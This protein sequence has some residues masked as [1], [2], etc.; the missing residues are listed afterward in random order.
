MHKISNVHKGETVFDQ[1]SA[2]RHVVAIVLAA[3]QGRRMGLPINKIFLPIH[4]KPVIIYTLEAFERCP[5][6]DEVLLVAAAGEEE[7]LA[8]LTQAAHCQK[9]RRIVQGGPTRHASEQCA[10]EALR[11]RIESGE[12]DL[13]LIHD[14]AR[15]FVLPERIQQLVETARAC[16][17]AILAMP[18]QEEE[19]IVEVDEQQ[20]ICRR[21]AGQR[22]WRAQ[23]P[24]AFRAAWLLAAY[25]RARQDQFEGT[26]TAASLERLGYPVAVVESDQSNLKITTAY[27]LLQAE[28]LC[29]HYGL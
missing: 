13:I 18:L 15:P 3:G 20:A 28:R 19:L 12:I 5:V 29:R 27:D 22:A 25:D 8:K 11:P 2:A 9:V 4:G 16:G 1:R 21:F 17:G 24:Q 7:Q 14:G 23:T 26:D 10:L 6:I